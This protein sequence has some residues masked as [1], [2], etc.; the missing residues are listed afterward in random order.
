MPATTVSCCARWT[1]IQSPP[2]CQPSSVAPCLCCLGSVRGAPR[3]GSRVPPH[4]LLQRKVHAHWISSRHCHQVLG[5]TA[6]NCLSPPLPLCVLIFLPLVLTFSPVFSL[7]LFFFLSST[8]FLSH[9][10]LPELLPLLAE[11]HFFFLSPSISSPL[12]T[13]PPRKKLS[14]L[15]LHTRHPLSQ[16]PPSAGH[17]QMGIAGDSE[18]FGS[19]RCL[20]PSVLVTEEIAK[21]F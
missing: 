15:Q 4:L 5:G 18:Q 7:V 20:L 1:L 17:T 16:G 6:V 12:S 11:P 13:L 3:R 2:C 14:L 8:F 10:H 9:E 21:G 19:S